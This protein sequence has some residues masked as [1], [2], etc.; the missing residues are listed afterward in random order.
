[1]RRM[2]RRYKTNNIVELVD[3]RRGRFG[4]ASANF[5]ASFLAAL[6]VEKD[7]EKYF[8]KAYWAPKIDAK[9]IK[10]NRSLSVKALLKW[11][12]GDQL[13]A[14]LYNPHIRLRTW[15]GYRLIQRR[16]F[17]RVPSP[18]YAQVKLEI[19]KLPKARASKG[20]DQFYKVSMGDTISEIAETYGV[21]PR[22]IMNINGLVNPRRIRAGQKI[23]IPK[24]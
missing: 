11:F 20:G 18:K 12:N 21:S 3:E 17:I 19:D 4:F 10:L 2:V 14:K 24:K 7:A 9:E 16:N 1:M 22:D 15:K 13:Q 23:I 6:E 8:K 5:Y